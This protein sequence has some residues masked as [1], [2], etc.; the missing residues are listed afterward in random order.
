MYIEYKENYVLYYA[1]CKSSQEYMAREIDWHTLIHAR[2]L[3]K[4]GELLALQHLEIVTKGN[5]KKSSYLNFMRIIYFKNIHLFYVY[6][7]T[8]MFVL[9]MHR[10]AQ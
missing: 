9:L 5:R 4:N 2:M 7:L 6:V 1:F 10:G 3:Q 8:Y